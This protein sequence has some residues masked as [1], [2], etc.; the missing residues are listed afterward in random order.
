MPRYSFSVHDDT[1]PVSDKGGGEYADLTEM[2][3]E[4]EAIARDLAQY[5]IKTNRP[6]TAWVEVR[7]C[8]G[9]LVASISV[10]EASRPKSGGNYP[11]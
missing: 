11:H 10:L 8:D 1:G 7:G 5:L 6:L 2:L 3:Q 9:V 4:A